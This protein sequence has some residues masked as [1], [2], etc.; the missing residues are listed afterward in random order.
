MEK[1]TEAGVSWSRHDFDA[2]VT[3]QD[4]TDS[5]ERAHQREYRELSEASNL[6]TDHVCVGR[7]ARLPG[8]C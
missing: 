7:H 8:V 3:M 4:L 5:C 6:L 1:S 2:N